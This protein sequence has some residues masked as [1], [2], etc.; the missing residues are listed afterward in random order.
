MENKLS[1]SLAALALLAASVGAQA[2]IVDFTFNFGWYG[3]RSYHG[4]ITGNDLNS[5]GIL[6]TNELTSIFES[7]SGHNSL[8]SLNDIGDINIAAQTWTPN[9]VSWN[10]YPDIAYMTFDNRNWSCST[11]NECGVT[12][13]SFS[14][15]PEPE[16]LALLGLSLAGL[17]FASRRKARQ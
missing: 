17:A 15:V 3:D 2:G 13:T 5:D 16:S 4:E 11:Y 14:A 6:T 10:G 9:A 1:K 7:Y 8:S 12:I